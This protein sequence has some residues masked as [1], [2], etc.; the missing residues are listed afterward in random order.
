MCLY[1]K[2]GAWHIDMSC[3]GMSLHTVIETMA[4]V[5]RSCILVFAT[6]RNPR[7]N[8]SKGVRTLDAEDPS[9]RVNREYLYLIV[10]TKSITTI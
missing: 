5:G 10:S 8:E 7:G 2:N 4:L 6:C 1:M 3:K 9:E